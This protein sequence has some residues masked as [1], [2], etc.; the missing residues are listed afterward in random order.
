[1]ASPHILE[2]P[3]GRHDMRLIGAPR[4]FI[5][6]A[7]AVA[8]GERLHNGVVN[9]LAMLA[10]SEGVQVVIGGASNSL[11]RQLEQSGVVWPPTPALQVLPAGQSVS[12][13]EVLAQA[14]IP[15]S[16][17]LIVL[18]HSDAAP[19]PGSHAFYVGRGVPA[20]GAIATRLSGPAGTDAL[21][22]LY[23]TALIQE[24]S[25]LEF[26]ATSQGGSPPT[27]APFDSGMFQGL[28]KSLERVPER[29]AMPGL[30]RPAP[31]LD[32]QMIRMLAS[33][34]FAR[35]LRN[36][37]PNGAIVASPAKGEQP[38]QP[39]YWFVWQRD[40]GHTLLNLIDWSRRAPFGLNT[41]QMKEAINSYIGFL[42]RCQAHGNLGTSRYTVDEQPVQGYGNPQ[43]DGPA[44]SALAMTK[45]LDPRP[46][47]PQIRAFLNYLLTPEGQGPCYDAWEFVYG[48]ICNA[49]LLKR[50]AF[51]AGARLANVLTEEEDARRYREE[52]GRLE[53]E[54]VQYIDQARGYLISS[55]EPA[56]PWFEQMSGLDVATLGAILTAWDSNDDFLNLTHP[57]VLGT[58]MALDAAFA[59]CYAINRA[60]LADGHEGL[61]WGR[62]PEDANDGV[63]STGGN[64]WPLVTLWG[65][66]F[67]YLLAE[68]LATAGPFL[69]TDE[70]Q[71]HYLNQVVGDEVARVG[72][73]LL[74]ER[75]LLEVLPA[76]RKR[77]DGYLRFVL[78]HQP[79]DGTL[80]EQINR[81]TGQPQGARDLTW[82]MG[83]LLSTLALRG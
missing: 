70:R 69:V 9:K 10:K 58:V 73:Q 8:E 41:A 56:N 21:L 44:L 40:A 36:V 34:C 68:K 27:S 63:G 24:K 15:A 47:Y 17:C 80:S 13:G 74:S 46:V 49:L 64:P 18:A 59:P 53:A 16:E 5:L 38:G 54:L 55:R 43:L 52:T 82:A 79:A 19:P 1:M 65:A 25:G 50:K 32:G 66:Q 23:G 26:R 62:F 30:A 75:I 31:E 12:P 76:L 22:A 83:E 57:A 61:G 35:V 67:C 51:R 29:E 33:T 37:Q 6:D 2:T 48:R 7:G 78:A 20:S 39:N 42:T 45:L 4:L 14:S 72:N 11:R 3:A 81:D 71:A 77:G 28:V 60:W